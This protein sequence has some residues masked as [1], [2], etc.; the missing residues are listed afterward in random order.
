MCCSKCGDES[1]GHRRRHRRAYHRAQPACAFL[2]S[3]IAHRGKVVKDAV[4]KIRESPS[5]LLANATSLLRRKTMQSHGN[6]YAPAPIDRTIA[7]VRD[8]AKGL[9]ARIIEA[10]KA[11]AD[12]YAAAARYEE[13]SKLSKGELKRRGIPGGDLPQHIFEIL[14]K[15]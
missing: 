12:G 15:R 9:G 6:A 2:K 14:T 7:E 11:C 1:N 8:Q 10:L 3:Q 5:K 13:L 4:I